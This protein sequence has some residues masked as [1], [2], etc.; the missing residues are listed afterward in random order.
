MSFVI[1]N[2]QAISH[3]SPSPYDVDIVDNRGHSLH[4]MSMGDGVT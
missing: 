4:C 3:P 1:N 2:L